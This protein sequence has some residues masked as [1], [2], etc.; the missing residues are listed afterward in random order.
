MVA[1]AVVI[2]LGYLP[3]TFL[4]PG[5]DLDVGGVYHAGQS[6]LEGDYQVSRLPGAPVFEAITAV[7]HAVGGSLLVNLVSV[8]MAVATALGVVRLLDREG[9]AHASWFGLAVLVNPFVWI[10]GTSMVDFLWAMAFFLVGANLHLSRRYSPAVVCFAMA[11]GCRL[12]T[13]VLVAALVLADLWSTPGERRRALVVGTATLALTAVVYLPP[14][15]QLGAGFVDSEVPGSALLVQ[16]GRFGAKNTFFFGPITI[17]F[18]VWHLPKLLAS[19]PGGWSRSMVLRLG[20]I[21][22][23]ASQLLYL[24]FPWK[25]AHLIPSLVCL[26]LVLAASRVISN[27]GV[28]VLIAAQVVLSVVTLNLAQPDRPNEATGGRIALQIV[29]GPLLHDIR[30]RVDGDQKA[31]RRLGAVQPLLDTWACVIPWSD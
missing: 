7:L 16:V 1:G 29:E 8:L 13:L 20:V 11:A 12:S 9:H 2:V 5:T 19:V 22:F 26:V 24:R 21:G 31:Y 23:V 18:V 10:A 30:C 14:F 3:L 28:A 15:L 6:I 17:A 4:G 27:R 25:L